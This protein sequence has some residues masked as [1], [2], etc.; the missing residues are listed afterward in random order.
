LRNF[1]FLELE[2]IDDRHEKDFGRI[3]S[4]I[5]IID[6]LFK[7]TINKRIQLID[8]TCYVPP[9]IELDLKE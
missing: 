4:S 8:D 7:K 5:W 2:F 6:F 3:E 9:L 1:S